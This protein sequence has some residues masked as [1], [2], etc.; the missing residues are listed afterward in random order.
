MVGKAVAVLLALALDACAHRPPPGP[1]AAPRILHTAPG[2][3]LPAPSAVIGEAKNVRAGRWCAV[4]HAFS[5]PV[6]PFPDG[7]TEIVDR[8]EGGV[9][10]KVYMYDRHDQ[11]V[12]VVRTRIKP[13]MRE[14]EVLPYT[15]AK[16]ERTRQVIP[17]MSSEWVQ[18]D[19][20]TQVQTVNPSTPFDGREYT[21]FLSLSQEAAGR[22]ID[23][24]VDR[25]FV[26]AGYYFH[27][28]VVARQLDP[29]LRK[30]DTPTPGH[31]VRDPCPF[32]LELA[33]WT[34]DNLRI[35]DRCDG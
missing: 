5:L 26:G 23:C 29:A 17:E 14:E 9:T 34:F 35:G 33:A 4:D 20:V 13:E 3:L 2:D 21:A 11:I 31:P 19:G 15:A 30:G 16:L 25:H 18:Q 28:I 1:P 7:P 6:V 24:R 32:A 10:A 12:E 27:I 8:Y 22:K